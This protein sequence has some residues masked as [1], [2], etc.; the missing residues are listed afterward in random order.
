M[1]MKD[2]LDFI[3]EKSLETF[4]DNLV[5]IYLH[6]S[7]AFGCFNWNQSDIDFIIVLNS[8]PSLF[9]KK[10]FL[11]DLL[12]LDQEAPVKGL[13]M[14]LVLDKYTRNFIYPT[15]YELHFSNAHKS[16]CQNDITLFCQTM[17]GLDKDL[18]A[19][20][21]IIRS[22]GLTLYGESEKTVFQPVPK[23]AYLDSIKSDVKNAASSILSQPVYYIL[24][25]CRVLA[26]ITDEKILSKADGG[27][28]GLHTLPDQ[29]SILIKMAIN[30][31]ETNIPFSVSSHH[32]LLL[33]F[34]RYME[35]QIFFNQ[36]PSKL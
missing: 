1:V 20:F 5:G 8:T 18:A 2:L 24:N 21:T 35:Q 17:H 26:Y 19:H 32:D 33:D 15:P 16:K 23:W 36:S 29:Y 27:T 3:K 34:A 14:S 13:E 6:G 31:Y 22:H 9:Q 11:S 30:S 10:A 12:Q 28:W 7:L 25:L 4:S